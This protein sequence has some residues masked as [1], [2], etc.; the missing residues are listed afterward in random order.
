MSFFIRISIISL[1]VII[2]IIAI[3]TNIKSPWYI[4]QTIPLCG[5]YLA[6]YYFKLNKGKFTI[7]SRIILYGLVLCLLILILFLNKLGYTAYLQPKRITQENIVFVYIISISGCFMI[8]LLSQ[9]LSIVKCKLTNLIAIVGEHSFSIMAL[10][11]L[12]FKLISFFIIITHHYEFSKISE[13]PII[14]TNCILWNLA[15]ILS[16]VTLPVITAIFYS[17]IKHFLIKS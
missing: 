2:N 13:F 1:L 12:A 3:K 4:W 14:Q 7:N 17:K 5:I 9:S 16:G 6:G 15:Y 11:F 10:H 8:Y